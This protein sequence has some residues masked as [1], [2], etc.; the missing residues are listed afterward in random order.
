MLKSETVN[1]TEPTVDLDGTMAKIK[2]VK[3][4]DELLRKSKLENKEY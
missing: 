1:R 3:L 2:N 4:V